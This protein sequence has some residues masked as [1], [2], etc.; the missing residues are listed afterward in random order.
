MITLPTRFPHILEQDIPVARRWL[1]INQGGIEWLEIDVRVGDG[2]PAPPG[3]PPNLQQMAVDLS[4]RRIDLVAGFRD[5]IAIVEVTRIAGFTALGQLL[6]YPELYRYSFK[7]TLPLI[8]TLVC[9]ELQ[10]DVQAVISQY[11]IVY[12]IL[13]AVTNV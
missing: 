4:Q 10:P 6:V 12:T 8:P 1:T 13:P 9:E 7:P 11:G 5:H 3:T 2:R